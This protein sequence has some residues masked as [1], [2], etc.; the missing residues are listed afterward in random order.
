MLVPALWCWRSNAAEI[1][2]IKMAMWIIRQMVGE[3]ILTD[4]ENGE[5][6]DNSQIPSYARVGVK[7]KLR[8]TLIDWLRS[9]ELD[10]EAS[11]RLQPDQTR[12]LLLVWLQR[13]WFI[14][15]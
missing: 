4:R 14:R 5:K 12:W 7:V 10:L 8:S 13:F 3:R 11:N 15:L 1:Y 9:V 2:K 6:G